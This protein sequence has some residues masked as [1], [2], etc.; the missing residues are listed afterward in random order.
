MSITLMI[1]N[2]IDF[3]RIEHSSNVFIYAYPVFKLCINISYTV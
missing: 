1:K 3:V 2:N